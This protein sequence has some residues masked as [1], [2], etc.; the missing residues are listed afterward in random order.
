MYCIYV[1]IWTLIK[2]TGVILNT[3]IFWDTNT[4]QIQQ[5]KKAEPLENLAHFRMHLLAEFNSA[6]DV[7]CTTGDIEVNAGNGFIMI[8]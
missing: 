1:R 5:R 8:Q 7:V 4:H 2:F 6:H 3:Y